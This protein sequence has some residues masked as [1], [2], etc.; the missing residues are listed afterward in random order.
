M[1]IAVPTPRFAIRA[2]GCTHLYHYTRIENLAGI[3]PR[4]IGHD[5]EWALGAVNILATSGWSMGRTLRD[6]SVLDFELK[7]KGRG[8]YTYFFGRPPTWWAQLKNLNISSGRSAAEQGFGIVRVELETLL[9]VYDGPT[10]CRPDDQAVV[11]RGGYSGP[12]AIGPGTHR[13]R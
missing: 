5:G 4:P 2:M 1:A 7:L 11:I 6:Y 12:G 9:R 13:P 8:V 3:M 10:F